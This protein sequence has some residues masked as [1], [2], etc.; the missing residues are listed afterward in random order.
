LAAA[1][2][3]SNRTTATSARMRKRAINIAL[4]L[5]GAC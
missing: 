1:V 4:R 5:P 3:G 2:D